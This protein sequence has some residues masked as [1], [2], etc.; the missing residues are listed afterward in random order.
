MAIGFGLLLAPDA[1]TFRYRAL[2]DYFLMNSVLEINGRQDEW[3]HSD[4]I[5]HDQRSP[6]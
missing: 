6:I 5:G 4:V 2:V 1:T 3:S